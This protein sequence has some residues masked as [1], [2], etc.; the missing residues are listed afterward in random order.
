[1]PNHVNVRVSELVYTNYTPKESFQLH[2][3]SLIVKNIISA[4]QLRIFSYFTLYKE[5]WA[6]MV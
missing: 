1:M 6:R 5:M 2:S 3:Y 4:L